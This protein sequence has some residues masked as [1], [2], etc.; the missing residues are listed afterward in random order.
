MRARN[1]GPTATHLHT[2]DISVNILAKCV[3]FSK[4]RKLIKSPTVFVSQH[5]AVSYKNTTCKI[6]DSSAHFGDCNMH[7]NYWPR[8]HPSTKRGTSHDELFKKP[9]SAAS[10][11]NNS[12]L[13]T[14]SF[15]QIISTD[16]RLILNELN[17]TAS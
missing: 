16:E 7:I 15:K 5:M 12:E 17:W 13:L 9:N 10:H 14:K 11:L 1:I 4:D 6:I 3:A 8:G 2:D